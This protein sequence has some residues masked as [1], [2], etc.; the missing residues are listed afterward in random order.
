MSLFATAGMKLHI[1]GPITDNDADMVLADFTSVT[2]VEAKNLDSMGSLGDTAQVITAAVIDRNRD[3][4]VKGT[5]NAGSMQVVF[6]IDYADPGQQAI[7]AAEKS[8][9]NFAFKV[10]MNDAPE[11]GTPSTRLFIA[12]VTSQAE[13]Y[14]T[15]NSI[16]KL[17]V[18]LEVNSNVVRTNAAPG[19]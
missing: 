5:R 15:A 13:Q 3:V 16:M 7:I 9:N 1:G 4:K 19:T 17:N 12:L 18:T 11:G 14:D 8:V 6:N 10:T 2:W